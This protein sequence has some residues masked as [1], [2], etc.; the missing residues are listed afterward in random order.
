MKYRIVKRHVERKPQRFGE[1]VRYDL[2]QCVPRHRNR[3]L[4]QV[5]VTPTA[6]HHGLLRE[7]DPRV[8]LA[9][10]QAVEIGT[11]HLSQRKVHNVRIPPGQ[12]GGA[13][14]YTSAV[15]VLNFIRS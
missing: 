15:I 3:Y 5:W 7:I 4:Q 13:L 14:G 6:L 2:Y 9:V 10:K 8:R 12:K 11:G 1:V